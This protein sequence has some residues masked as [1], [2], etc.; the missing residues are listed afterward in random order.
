MQQN[1]AD[2]MF[3][4]STSESQDGMNATSHA[5]QLRPLSSTAGYQQRPLAPSFDTGSPLPAAFALWPPTPRTAMDRPA[6][7]HEST[8]PN[9]HLPTT[10]GGW[11]SMY[12]Q[13]TAAP[14]YD[15]ANSW[16][17]PRGADF[18]S[19]LSGADHDSNHLGSSHSSDE[20]FDMR[21]NQRR[22][23]ESDTLNSSPNLSE[24]SGREIPRSSSELSC[25]DD[26]TH[27]DGSIMGD[28]T[29]HT[30]PMSMATTPLS[31]VMS[32]RQSARMMVRQSVQS[33]KASP[34]PRPGI[35]SAPYT[36]ESSRNKRWS[37]GCY[38]NNAPAFIP[39]NAALFASPQAQHGHQHYPTYPLQPNN[40]LLSQQQGYQ[41]HAAPYMPNPYMDMEGTTAIHIHD[42]PIYPNMRMLHS[43]AEPHHAH[44]ADLSDPPD[45]YGSLSEEPLDPPEEDMNPE[46]PEAKPHEQPGRFDGDLYTPKWV[47]YQGNRREGWCGF[48]K[49]GRWLVLKNSA[50]WYDKSFTHGISAATGQ[51]FM[52][53]QEVR[54]MDGNPDVWEG[55]CHSCSDW[56][57]L[58]SNKK[59]GT[60]WF[61]HAYKCHTH[62]KVKD[63]PKRRRD[64]AANKPLPPTPQANIGKTE[65]QP[66][67][68]TYEQP[69][70]SSVNRGYAD[71]EYKQQ[72][73]DQRPYGLNIKNDYLGLPIS[74]GQF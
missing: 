44:Y 20:Y 3:S 6:T 7:I 61:R 60:A 72:E 70:L 55:L 13:V 50:F 8:F 36:T 64:A 37:T 21:L 66:P 49:P 74:A 9:F 39:E 33:R 24:I 59:K 65:M 17:R 30:T 53:P 58:V 42:H 40:Y 63:A 73:Y 52:E 29:R 18:T 12:N 1:Y 28:Y 51:Q 2:N 43:N 32:P 26:S 62:A 48:C 68:S 27:Y 71:M 34:S 5:Q 11:D 14:S 31:P 4:Y 69:P 23:A 57:P 67:L 45:L 56:V 38:F 16:D 10:M 35:R 19:L 41:Q 46:D 22:S 25:Y 15:S 54:R 47:R